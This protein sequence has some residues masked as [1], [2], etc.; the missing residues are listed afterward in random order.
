M[1]IQNLRLRLNN[2]RIHNKIILLLA[3]L[4]TSTLIMSGLVSFSTAS[5]IVNKQVNNNLKSSVEQIAYNLEIILRGMKSNIEL[6]YQDRVTQ[7]FLGGNNN[8]TRQQYNDIIMTKISPQNAT[9]T[10]LFSREEMIYGYNINYIDTDFNYR[11]TIEYRKCKANNDKITWITTNHLSIGSK[12]IPENDKD[13]LCIASIIKDFDS[14]NEVGFMVM[15]FKEN[16]IFNVYNKIK[17]TDGAYGFIIDKEGY[18]VSHSNKSLLGSKYIH[19]PELNK[20]MDREETGSFLFTIDNTSNLVFYDTLQSTD[21]KFIYVIP[22]RDLLKDINLIRDTFLIVIL[23]CFIISISFAF[24]VSRSITKPIGNIVSVMSRFGKGDMTVRITNYGER[25]DEVGVLA[26]EFNSVIEKINDLIK[27]NYHNEIKKK[28]AEMMA[29][30]AQINPHFLYNTLDCINFMARKYKVMEISRMV[31]ALGDLM[32]I[33]IRKD[34]NM[35]TVKDEIS[36]IQNYMTIQKIRYR[37]KLDLTVN[38][39]ESLNKIAIPKLILQ[40]LVENAVAHGI[41]PKVGKGTIT[42]NGYR[43]ED[44]AVFEIIDD[45]IGFNDV[46]AREMLKNNLLQYDNINIEQ[47]TESEIGA[48]ER[49]GTNIGLLNVDMRLKLIYGKEY[50]IA[51]RSKTGAGTTITVKLPI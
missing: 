19:Y 9:A 48:G 17:M 7:K 28:E 13:R 4:I 10:Y 24:L 14:M 31:I 1:F 46:R 43:M 11:Y 12:L 5:K 29:L 40:P 37:D 34:R 3:T 8:Y 27:N 32:R 15:T 16:D 33:S 39:E 25:T 45:G 18:I 20:K 49:K 44:K 30:Q 38:V 50:G 51:L 6:V 42:L 21:W 26:N 36:Y 22:A 41:E 23:I 35:I 2:L 47:E